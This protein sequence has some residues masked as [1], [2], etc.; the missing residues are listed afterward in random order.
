[1][2]KLHLF[3]PTKGF[4][5]FSYFGTAAKRYLI[6]TN[7][8]VYRRKLES[9]SVDNVSD[10]SRYLE[11]KMSKTS[12]D[13]LNFFINYWITYCDTYM[14]MYFKD[15]TDKKTADAVL[16]LFRRRFMLEGFKKK[17]LYAGIRE[18]VPGI[19]TSRITKVVTILYD[20]I[21]WPHYTYYLEHDLLPKEY[22]AIEPYKPYEPEEPVVVIEEEE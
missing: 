5:A 11:D 20:K 22:D 14:D 16:E 18:M 4:K 15:D 3:D 21:L 1:M 10:E 9:Q 7:D 2:S 19:K 8:K 13:K 6:N 17:V 12:H